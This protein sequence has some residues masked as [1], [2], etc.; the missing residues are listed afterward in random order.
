MGG[1]TGIW[2]AS[3]VSVS[4]APCWPEGESTGTVGLDGLGSVDWLG[5]AEGGA[6]E[7]DG[8]A[9]GG[10]AVRAGSNR[11]RAMARTTRAAA[12]AMATVRRRAS[13]NG[14]AI[15]RPGRQWLPPPPGW[16]GTLGGVGP[17]LGSVDH[18]HGAVGVGHDG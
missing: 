5:G 14:N 12:S 4:C 6:V 18:Q 15:T 13:L 2:P 11:A 10:P 8:A 1:S 17:A 3:G 16:S 7:A 9:D